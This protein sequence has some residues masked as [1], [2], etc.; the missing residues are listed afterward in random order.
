MVRLGEEADLISNRSRRLPPDLAAI[1]ALV[2]FVPWRTLS[3]GS[4]FLILR[5]RR[6]RES[7]REGIEERADRGHH[8]TPGRKNSVHQSGVSF[9]RRQQSDQRAALQIRRN[10]EMR[11]K[12]C[13]NP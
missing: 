1:D 7:F 8:P 3:I 4:N 6:N 13:T 5:R 9:E 11:D 10:D 12:D 2:R